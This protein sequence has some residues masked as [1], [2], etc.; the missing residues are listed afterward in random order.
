M[1]V[2]DVYLT[3]IFSSLALL[4]VPGPAVVYVINRGVVD[5]RTVALSSVLGLTLGNFFHAVLAGIGVSAVLVAST[6]AFNIV[7]WLGVAYLIGTGVQTL[8]SRVRPL[9]LVNQSIDTSRAFRQGVTVN[10]LN[11]KVALFFLAFVP[12]FVDESSNDS[13][14]T[15]LFIGC[16]FVGM[17]L[18]T[19][20][21]Y[22]LASSAL[23]EK[24][25]R[26][27]ALPFFRRWVSGTVF[28]VL[29]TLAA[30]VSRT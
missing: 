11:P 18:I 1:P 17:G 29:G 20:S 12:Q 24:V 8:T 23:R 14:W 9:D 22:A 3:F 15:T 2:L 5:G 7:K 19:D 13:A 26:G 4:L 21:A 6:I 30:T 28:L 16:A 25:M 27:R 10:L